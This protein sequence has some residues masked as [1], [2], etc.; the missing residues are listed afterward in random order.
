MEVLA[1]KNWK[2]CRI[3]LSSA[4]LQY[5]NTAINN[6]VWYFRIEEGTQ[7]EGIREQGVEEDV[8]A[9]EGRGNWGVEK[10]I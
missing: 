4:E 5:N 7:P 10:T 3:H 9:Q 2:Y 6:V 1:Y 8:W